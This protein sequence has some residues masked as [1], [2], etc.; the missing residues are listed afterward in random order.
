M[1]QL[2][3][4]S[5]LNLMRTILTQQF[6]F[7]SGTGSIGRTFLNREK[8][9]FL[10]GT[11]I[12]SFGTSHLN[13][14]PRIITEFLLFLPR[15]D[16]NYWWQI[17]RLRITSS[18][19]ATNP[20]KARESVWRSS[21]RSCFKQITGSHAVAFTWA[22]ALSR[23]KFSWVPEL[24]MEIMTRCRPTV[25][26]KSFVVKSH[27]KFRASSW[28]FA[29]NDEGGRQGLCSRLRI[30]QGLSRFEHDKKRWLQARG[31]GKCGATKEDKSTLTGL[32]SLR[33]VWMDCGL[34]DFHRTFGWQEASQCQ[35][36]QICELLLGRPDWF[37]CSSTLL[38]LPLSKLNLFS[39]VVSS[40]GWCVKFPEFPGTIIEQR[41]E[42]K[43]CV[44]RIW[45]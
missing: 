30:D 29:Q 17:E 9:F 8:G 43:W 38:W 41:N 4:F 18:K 28:V 13:K 16:W 31:W 24:I 34:E 27:F 44:H 25:L 15:K 19:Q 11:F 45:F 39:K 33:C 1:L 36:L 20:S 40:S 26:R 6:Q 37:Y 32:R 10:A 3:C 14:L 23:G 5:K 12:A 35:P 21:F 2:I 42:I 7:E 22:D